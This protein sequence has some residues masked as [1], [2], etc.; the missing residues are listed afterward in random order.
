MS[1]STELLSAATTALRDIYMGYP[2]TEIKAPSGTGIKNLLRDLVAYLREC[3]VDDEG[4]WDCDATEGIKIGRLSVKPF[5]L[6]IGASATSE[7]GE[8]PEWA[9]VTVTPEFL[10]TLLRLRRV[11]RDEKLE[12]VTVS[13][14]PDCWDQEEYFRIRGDSLRVW[15]N[16]FWFEAHPKYADYNV[17]TRAIDIDKLLKVVD[18]I[19]KNDVENPMPE[20]F[21]VKNGVVFCGAD[22]DDLADS[23]FDF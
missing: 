23:C 2:E 13:Q 8:G 16:D 1:K 19:A 7:F 6:V 20:G 9:G 12:S 5:K 10:Q 11:C 4:G 15:G 21:S 22:P 3:G 18:K 14:A 17:E